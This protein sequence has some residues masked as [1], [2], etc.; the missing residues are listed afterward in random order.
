[1]DGSCR[2]HHRPKRLLELGTAQQLRLARRA[3]GERAAGRTAA[4]MPVEQRRLE[5]GQHPVEA[6]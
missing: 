3:C 5:R 6:K 4:Q 1:M 2:D